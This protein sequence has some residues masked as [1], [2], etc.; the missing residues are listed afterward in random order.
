MAF[1]ADER[2]KANE[3]ARDLKALLPKLYKATGNLETLQAEDL[4]SLDLV[5]GGNPSEH[6]RAARKL[7]RDASTA[8]EAAKTALR[9]NENLIEG[10]KHYEIAV[11]CF[12]QA[13]GTLVLLGAPTADTKPARKD[14]KP[15]KPS[16]E[17]DETSKPVPAP[18]PAPATPVTD[19]KGKED[20][21]VV[22][23]LKPEP[24]KAKA[25]DEVDPK[26]PFAKVL[27]AINGVR[28]TCAAQHKDVTDRLDI[29]ATGTL[30]PARAKAIR[31]IS[32]DEFANLMRLIS[33]LT[34]TGLSTLE[35]FIKL[36]DE[37]FDQ[38][39]TSGGL[40]ARV[41]DLEAWRANGVTLEDVK[42]FKGKSWKRAD[43]PATTDPTTH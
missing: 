14:D 7:L 1:T 26:D 29:L 32:D 12:T 18:K 19:D 9:T 40:T 30:Q 27:A 23:V 5:G 21:K 15:A 11:R 3:L 34:P 17:T 42:F 16:G 28:D 20:P 41:E 8:W 2:T 4:S 22:P 36:T 31:E 39:L 10:V 24:P 33:L 43:K 37:Q 6:L 25:D 35:A 38:I 13:N